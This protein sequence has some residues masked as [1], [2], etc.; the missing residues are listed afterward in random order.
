MAHNGTYIN[1]FLF[2]LDFSSFEDEFKFKFTFLV[3][4]RISFSTVRDNVIYGVLCL[5]LL[6]CVIFIY[7]FIAIIHFI[8]F[9]TDTIVFFLIK[10]H[11]NS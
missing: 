8:P 1:I 3:F 5:C 10:L 7:F 2:H 11:H 4:G 6:E 9:R